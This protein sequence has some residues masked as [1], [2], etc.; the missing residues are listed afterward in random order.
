MENVNMVWRNIHNSCRSFSRRSPTLILGSLILMM[1]LKGDEGFMLSPRTSKKQSAEHYFSSPVR[2]ASTSRCGGCYC[3]HPFRKRTRMHS[4]P[5]LGE[6]VANPTFGDTAGAMVVLQGCVVSQGDTELMSDVDLSV[7]P[8]E[9][10]GLVGQNG[11]GKSSLLQC[12]AGFRSTDEGRCLI[13]NGARMGYLQQKGVSGSTRTVYEEACSE[14]HKINRA[15]EAMEAA[16]A[17]VVEDPMSQ[18][19]LDRLLETQATFEAVGGMTQDRLVAQIL[20]GL[21]FTN[22]DQQR[23]CST[24]SGGW[25]M[26]IALGKLLLSEP[27]LLLLD[28]PTNHLD[29]SAKQWLAKFLS[30]YTG[31]LVTV[32]HDEDLLEGVDLSTVA[33]VANKRVEVF[34]GC[35][36]KRF[37]VEREERMKAAKAKY[38][39]EQKEMA[40]LQGF[41]DRFGAQA[42]KASAAQSRVKML[43]KME[44]NSAPVPEET[45]AFKAKIKL[46]TPPP[47]HNKQVELVNATFGWDGAPPTAAG[48]NLKLEKGQTVAILGPNGAGKSTLLKALAAALPLRE[49]QRLEG[50][51]LKLGVFTQDLAQDLPQDAV[52]LELVL[53]RVREHDT[54]VSDQQA[55]TVLGSLGLA[56]P[57]ALRKIGVL[58]GGEKARVALAIF[59][60]IPYNLLMLDEPSNHLDSETLGAL[61]EAI[62]GWKGTVVVV[63][64]NK[65]FITRLAPSHTVIVK[66]GEVKVRDRPPIDK[67][68]NH[69][70]DEQ[71]R[72]QDANGRKREEVNGKIKGN[73]KKLM[74]PEDKAEQKAQRVAADKAR[75]KKLNAPARIA[76]IQTLLEDVEGKMEALMARLYEEGSDPSVAAKLMEDKEEG[77]AKIKKLYQEWEELEDLL[78]EGYNRIG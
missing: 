56:G 76:K 53:D 51:G 64:H 28:E 35:G 61:V 7:M 69:H 45:K 57:K 36:F 19:A 71:H 63:S 67:D 77:D 30:T 78:Q 18:K 70:Q 22:Q 32:S 44:A 59:V 74:V 29:A 10:V 1:K 54:T 33:E 73:A 43:A 49:G 12:I 31:T 6:Q 48:V 23:L 26:R 17:K 15:R 24:F 72:K 38:E 50:E 46:P 3:C 68:W 40:R 37:L 75:K 62:K 55:R 13:K 47:C 2:H 34:K 58:S 25:Q 65:E 4:S 8:G 14:M 66:A 52:A 5:V 11:A 27:D 60:M 42:T 21:G 39:L 16:E 9:R 20:G 41:I